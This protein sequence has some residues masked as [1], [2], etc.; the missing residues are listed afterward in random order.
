LIYATGS[1]TIAYSTA[2]YD[3]AAQ[4]WTLASTQ[5]AYSAAGIIATNPAFA[6]DSAGNLWCGFTAEN[7][8]TQEYQED[9]IYQ[10]AG[11]TEWVD[12]GL[13]FGQVDNT[14]QHSAR[15]VAYAGGIGVLYEDEAALYWAY[16]LNSFALDAPWVST[17]MYADLPPESADPYDTHYSVVADSDNNLYLAFIGAPANLIF[18]IFSSSANTWGPLQLLG[19]STAASAYPEISIADGNLLLMANHVTDVEVLQSRNFGKSF[20]ETQVLTHPPVTSGVS[21]NKPRVETPR[22]STS[23]V[24][25]FQQFVDGSEDELMFFQVPVIN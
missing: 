4:S 18:T 10:L 14:T 1:G 13:I 2:T 21:Y 17:M 5:T 25:V 24:P 8:A 19:K 6:S 20:R 16:R 15:P 12:T 11:A 9:M 3:S 22:Y 23:P 7:S